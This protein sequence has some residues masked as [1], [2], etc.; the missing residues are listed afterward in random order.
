[1]WATKVN[2]FYVGIFLKIEECEV[3]KRSFLT[4]ASIL[5]KTGY[6]KGWVVSNIWVD[7]Y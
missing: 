7:I 4:Y 2:I 6:L 1:M 5:G 3:G